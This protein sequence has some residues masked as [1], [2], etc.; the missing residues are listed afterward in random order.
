ML[1]VTKITLM[2]AT[3]LTTTNSFRKSAPNTASRE[4]SQCLHGGRYP[5][6]NQDLGKIWDM[7]CYVALTIV[8]AYVTM[9]CARGILLVH[10][11]NDGAN[12]PADLLSVA[13]A[14]VGRCE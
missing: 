1:G 4:T 9:R 6:T 8:D 13:H 11:T 10:R 3:S 7:C 2:S 5:L 12:I 14:Y